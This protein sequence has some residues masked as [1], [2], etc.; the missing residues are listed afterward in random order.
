MTASKSVAML[1]EVA[2][3]RA[4]F[5]PDTPIWLGV[6]GD[7]YW[8]YIPVDSPLYTGRTTSGIPWLD[9][10]R[11]R[12]TKFGVKASTT[13]CKSILC[14]TEQVVSDLKIAAYIHSHFPRLLSA[15]KVSKG[16]VAPATVKG[17]IEELAR[18][19]SF[20]IVEVERT[21]GFEVE[22]LS[23]IT[24]PMLRDTVGAY[25]KNRHLKRAL[26]LISDPI[27]QQNLS[28][29]LQWSLLDVTKS[30]LV[31]AQP[32]DGPGIA[33]LSDA[34][35]VFLLGHCKSSITKFKSLAGMG[36]RDVECAAAGFSTEISTHWARAI[37]AYCDSS[38]VDLDYVEFKR[39]F[40][41]NMEEVRALV[42]DAHTSAMMVILLLT[43]MRASDSKFLLN[44]CLETHN[45]FR[46]LKSK[47]VKNQPVDAPISDGWLVVD[48]TH[49]AYDIL[50]FICNNTKNKYLFSSAN[51][52]W[53]GSARGYRGG[54]LNIK[55]SR[56]IET[57]DTAGL[58]ADWSFSVHQCRESLV[59]QLAKQDVGLAFISM[60]LKHFHSKLSSLPSEV[61][62]GYG[63]YRNELFD[64]ISRR[65]ADA[66][67]EAL[68]DIYGEDARFAGGG[69]AKHKARI[70]KFFTG[71]GLHGSSRESYIKKLAA[72]GA[73]LMPTSIGSCTKN[74]I[75]PD[76]APEP[77]CYGDYQCDPN[78]SSHVM[79]ERSAVALKMRKDHA[80]AS[81]STE[82]TAEFKVIWT[83]LADR[84]DS[85]IKKFAEEAHHG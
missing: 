84:L 37:A 82:P 57:I 64:S 4:V 16:K 21:H 44:G 7:D 83:S 62:A 39:Q 51:H 14:L 36:I 75:A 74:F 63:N 52:V 80:L 42:S 54:T 34:Q 48:L 12:G 3:G 17:R 27:V 71:L 69:A 60:Q 66:R 5:R 81:A 76:E 49:D 67:E 78:C 61:T 28:S 38:K 2:H 41:I 32:A 47:H 13:K 77:A 20:L 72:R 23:D 85:H 26:K 19:F 43:G 8:P 45:G 18:F 58:F 50:S 55:F 22:H 1:R 10:V 6:F 53:A 46:F 24:F 59:Y 33:T 56:W 65:A 15:S 25:P 40:S 73:R 29:P 68:L 70:D 31:F 35:F 79:T 9:Y 11:G 30:S